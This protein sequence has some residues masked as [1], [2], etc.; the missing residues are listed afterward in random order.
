MSTPFKMKNSA[1]TMSAKAGTPINY[2]SPAKKEKGSKRTQTTV[3]NTDKDGNV[4]PGSKS[5]VSVN[6]KKTKIFKS[7]PGAVFVDGVEQ[8]IAEKTKS[9]RSGNRSRKVSYDSDTKT[10]TRTNLKTGK[11]RTTTA[12]ISKRDQK[13][14]DRII[15][16]S[17]Q[18]KK[19]VKS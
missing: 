1:L 3:K 15:K 11:V 16:K 10:T 6:P 7:N 19:E 13:R 12:K 9:S 2:G 17:N 18:G 4:I 8:P 14:I 5:E